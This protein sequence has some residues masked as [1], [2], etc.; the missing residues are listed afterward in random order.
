M[1]KIS[2]DFT[3]LRSKRSQV[4]EATQPTL[5]LGL[6]TSQFLSDRQCQISFYKASHMAKR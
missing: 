2:R 1:E 6:A 4:N 5:T 3:E